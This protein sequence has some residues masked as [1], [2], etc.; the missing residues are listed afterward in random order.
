MNEDQVMNLLPVIMDLYA[1]AEKE[2]H[3]FKLDKTRL[4]DYAKSVMGK[5]EKDLCDVNNVDEFHTAM[6]KAYQQCLFN[7]A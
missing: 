6:K 2:Y 4:Y 3:S 7:A 5:F 1:N